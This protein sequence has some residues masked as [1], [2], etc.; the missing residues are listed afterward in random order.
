MELLQRLLL[1][2]MVI[3]IVMAV[4]LVMVDL[5]ARYLDDSDII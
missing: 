5:Q 1:M 4:L 3:A 2:A